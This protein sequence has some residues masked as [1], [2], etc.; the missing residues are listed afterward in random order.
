MAILGELTA[1][2]VRQQ[3]F[4]TAMLQRRDEDGPNINATLLPVLVAAAQTGSGS[5]SKNL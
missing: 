4:R 1:A 5:L 3:A 2:M